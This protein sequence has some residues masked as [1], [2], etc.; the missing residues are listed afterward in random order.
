MMRLIA[1][2]LTLLT[3]VVSAEDQF[4][5]VDSVNHQDSGKSFFSFEA[6][7]INQSKGDVILVGSIWHQEFKDFRNI[8]V[9][10]TAEAQKAVSESDKKYSV[11]GY[12][13]RSHERVF[14]TKNST[15]LRKMLISKDG[16]T[17]LGLTDD[18]GPLAI[19]AVVAGSAVALCTAQVVYNMYKCE[20]NKP[21]LTIG[22]GKEGFT[23]DARCE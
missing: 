9:T 11:G 7:E 20:T 2:G 21:R 13:Y 18:P 8:E 10:V 3:G 23:C 15:I 16:K 6:G 12:E 22:F 19:A 1:M 4:A 14:K 17:M 5:L